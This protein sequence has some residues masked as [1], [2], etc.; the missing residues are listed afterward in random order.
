MAKEKTVLR[1][2]AREKLD[3]LDLLRYIDYEFEWFHGLFEGLIEE[4]DLREKI[5]RRM[6]NC[7]AMTR[8]LRSRED[9]RE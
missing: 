7:R 8:E 1:N 2:D 5:K 3:S 4:P 6:L 9:A